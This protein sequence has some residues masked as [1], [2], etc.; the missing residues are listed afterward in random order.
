MFVDE[1]NLNVLAIMPVSIGGRLTTSSM[2]DGFRQN[3]FV[4]D[5]FDELYDK[6]FSINKNYKFIIGYDFSPI[7]IKVDNKL[8]LP[9]IAY[10]SDC[11]RSR[12]SGPEWKKYL[13]YLED[14]TNHIFYWD[15]E[16][17]KEENLQNIHYMP[18]FVN[19]DIYKD[20]QKESEFDVMFAGRLDTDYRLNF[21]EELVNK[22]PNIKF[23]WY[24]INRHYEDA[25]KRSKYPNLIEKIYQGFIDN[26]EDMA[27]AINNSRIV[28]NMHSQGKSNLNYRTFQTV[29]CKR[30]LISDYREELDLFAENIPYYKDVND[31]A[32]KIMFYLKNPNEYKST[33]QK[34]YEIGLKNHNSKDCVIQMLELIK[35]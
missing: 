29:A 23:C 7:K 35:K 1:N 19:F 26:E 4:V 30:L 9:L 16:L 12:T 8:D 20:F 28:F 32:Q 3:G 18:H 14:R 27:K 2:I 25:K 34:V 21:F 17:V 10:F 11:I 24:A 33:T 5:V 15:K 6:D 13:P 31:L 22:L